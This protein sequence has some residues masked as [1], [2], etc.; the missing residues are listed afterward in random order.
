MKS[1]AEK[2]KLIYKKQKNMYLDFVF[3]WINQMYL[4]FVNDCRKIGE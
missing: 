2:Q 1:E 3:K 4:Y